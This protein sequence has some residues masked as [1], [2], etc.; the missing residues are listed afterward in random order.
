MNR[1]T[2]TG[3]DE[4][5]DVARLV[6][7]V[8]RHPALE[9]GLLY[10]ATPEGRPRYPSLDWLQRTAAAL[11]G[12]CAVHVCGTRARQQLIAGELEALT[13]HAPRIQVNG[14]LTAD[15]VVAC[16]ERVGTLI[17]Q[18]HDKNAALASIVVRNHALLVD[19]SGGRGV[20]PEAWCRP[21][22]VK[23]VG[24]AGGL[25]PDNLARELG[26]IGRVATASSWVDMEG[27]LRTIRDDQMDWF[28]IGLAEHC[29]AVFD[30]H[31]AKP[32]RRARAV[33]P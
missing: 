23:A 5:T 12:R 1:I 32:A 29:A 8:Q 26:A 24:F 6:D 2:L 21:R 11:S 31:V 28:D 17:T 13:A 33:A 15:D 30:A 18:H 4:R 20:M 22:T 19:A 25:G 16:A 7:L 27:K 14:L 9:V 3:A 10:T